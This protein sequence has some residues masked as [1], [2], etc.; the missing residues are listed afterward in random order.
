MQNSPLTN[1]GA[2]TI[3]WERADEV[4]PIFFLFSRQTEYHKKKTGERSCKK[5]LCA[6]ANLLKEWNFGI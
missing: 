5:V 3:D 6:R 1:T 2:D 4:A